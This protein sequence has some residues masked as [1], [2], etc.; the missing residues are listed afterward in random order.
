MGLLLHCYINLFTD[1]G[2][3]KAYLLSRATSQLKEHTDEIKKGRSL[4]AEARKTLQVLDAEEKKCAESLQ[5]I[6]TDV[7]TVRKFDR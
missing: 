1:H 6:R 7:A 3:S 5:E 4:I 2:R